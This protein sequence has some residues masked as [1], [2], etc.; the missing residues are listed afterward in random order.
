MT[1]LTQVGVQSD[2]K[3]Q[4]NMALYFLKSSGEFNAAVREWETKPTAHQTWAN[5]KTFFSAE[6]SKANKQNKLTAKQ[7]RTNAKKEQA[8]ATEELIA[9]LI[10][11]HTRQMETLIKS[12]TEA[13]KEMLSLLKGYNTQAKTPNSDS[14][15]KEKKRRYKRNKFCNAPICKHCDKKH[16]SKPEDKCWELA[17]N[18]ASHPVSWKLTKST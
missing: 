11:A 3:E 17:K 14:E 12:T 16:P 9:Q 13:I 15:E 2:Q 10:E 5:I 7:F 6:Y 1:Q 4:I 18:V 8:E